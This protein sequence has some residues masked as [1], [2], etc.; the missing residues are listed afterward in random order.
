MKN[1]L[2]KISNNAVIMMPTAPSV[3]TTGSADLDSTITTFMKILFAGAIFAAIAAFI[4]LGM[5]YLRPSKV[6]EAKDQ[7]LWS[8]LGTLMIFSAPNIVLFLS[9]MNIL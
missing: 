5:Q 9:K 1:I 3:P 6:Q 4:F 8:F 2:T 7:T